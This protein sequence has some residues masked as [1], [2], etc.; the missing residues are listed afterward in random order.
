[1]PLPEIIIETIR[2][3][4]PLSFHDFME[5]ALYHPEQG[6]YSSTQDRVGESGDFYTSPYLTNLFGEMI[7][8]QLEEMWHILGRKPFTIVEYGAGTGLL[9]HDIL[10]KLHHNTELFAKTQYVIIEKGEG[11][12]EKEHQLLSAKNLPV[13]WIDSIDELPPITGC[14]LSN[15]LIDNF[16]VHRVIMQDELMEIFVTYDDGFKELLQPASSALKDYLKALQVTLPKGAIAEI[17]LEATAWIGEVAAALQKGFVLTIDYGTSS[18]ALYHDRSHTGTLVC[19]HKHKRSS[20]PYELIGEQDITS[21]VNFS[22]LEHWGRLGGLDYCG[23]TSQSRFLLGLGLARRMQQLEMTGRLNGNAR[24][25]YTL[26]MEMGNK[27]KVLIQSRGVGRTFLS[28]LQF[29]QVLA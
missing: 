25:L 29:S 8:A 12:R 24:Q 9:C 5:M 28:G 1:M 7:A 15:E 23:Y 11:M 20:D 26:L 14:I 3:Q 2:R 17:N 19:Y 27:F 22:A 10:E 6:Y 21:H 16:A 13:R 4:G 18:S